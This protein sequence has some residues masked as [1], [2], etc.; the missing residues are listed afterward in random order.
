[1]RRR[2]DK[3]QIKKELAD[4]FLA[5]ICGRHTDLRSISSIST[6]TVTRIATVSK[7]EFRFQENTYR[8]LN[9]SIRAWRQISRYRTGDP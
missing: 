2:D 1:M 5:S 8:S 4:Q 3:S 7:N 6:Y 9:V